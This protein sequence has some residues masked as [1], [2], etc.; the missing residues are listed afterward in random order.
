MDSYMK[1][2]FRRS[3]D[4]LASLSVTLGVLLG[5][6]SGCTSG[7]GAEVARNK[8]HRMSVAQE[9]LVEPMAKGENGA[10]VYTRRRLAERVNDWARPR[11]TGVS[12]SESPVSVRGWP[13]SDGV[14]FSYG[15]VRMVLPP[16]M[17][18]LALDTTKSL[19]SKEAAEVCLVSH[20]RDSAE[21]PLFIHYGGYVG[22]V[23]HCI[24]AAANE[25]AMS[26]PS[27]AA[28]QELVEGV[29][30]LLASTDEEL[31]VLV[32]SLDA[33]EVLDAKDTRAEMLL[34]ASVS[35]DLQPVY[36]ATGW[37]ILKTPDLHIYVAQRDGRLGH[38]MIVFDQSGI[39][40]V[41]IA[42]DSQPADLRDALRT[43]VTVEQWPH[44]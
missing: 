43:A 11:A 38:D 21:I 17:R 42:T 3:A 41:S 31:F 22:D 40:L 5:C 10:A 6:F 36:A 19:C 7:G 30:R 26:I 34:L 16:N 4:G 39:L 37:R 20:L 9:C 15:G 25:V 33:K 1:R 44:D 12:I 8:A 2:T 14:L 23:R 18:I 35:I 13:K 32:M 29:R 27:Q 24:E 28:N